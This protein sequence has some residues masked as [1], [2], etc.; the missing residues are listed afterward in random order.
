[1]PIPI[2]YQEDSGLW[3]DLQKKLKKQVSRRSPFPLALALKIETQ[4]EIDIFFA[5]KQASINSASDFQPSQ[6]LCLEHENARLY[7]EV[8]QIVTSR[9]LCWVRPLMLMVVSDTSELLPPMAPYDL[10]YSADLLWPIAFFR[11]ALDTEV[12]PLLTQLESPE[13]QISDAT[14]ANKRLNNF[15]RQ[16]WQADPSAF[17]PS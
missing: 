12:I 1:M 14:A 8:I 2:S 6:I 11:A 5:V 13:T 16:V 7:A 17:Q 15:I 10:R 3:R 9:C 4:T